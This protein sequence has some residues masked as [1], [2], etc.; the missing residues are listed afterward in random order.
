MTRSR[1]DHKANW[2]AVLEYAILLGAVALAVA[3][4]VGVVGSPEMFTAVV[5]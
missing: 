1:R 2:R 4:G 3:L 5:P